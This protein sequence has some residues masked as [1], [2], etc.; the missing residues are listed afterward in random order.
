MNPI[1]SPRDQVIQNALALQ[2][3]PYAVNLE[4][5]IGATG[6]TILYRERFSNVQS[7]EERDRLI[8]QWRGR[9]RVKTGMGWKAG[10][11]VTRTNSI[12]HFCKDFFLPTVVNR[13]SKEANLAFRVLGCVFAAILDIVTLPVRFLALLPLTIYRHTSPN[14]A[15]AILRARMTQANQEQRQLIEEALTLNQ[16]FIGYT[17]T[18]I[19]EPSIQ[20]LDGSLPHR[21]PNQPPTVLINTKTVRET[22]VL[23]DSRLDNEVDRHYRWDV[24]NERVLMQEHEPEATPC[25]LWIEK[26]FY[27][28]RHWNKYNG[29]WDVLGLNNSESYVNRFRNELPFSELAQIVQNGIESGNLCPHG[30]Y[31]LAQS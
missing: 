3:D 16:V 4:I 24:T 9:F 17:I 7:Q 1:L 27:T 30:G 18:E 23:N 31:S 14:P 11:V 2:R 5:R 22:V 10:L 15:I 19:A 25:L 26:P 12:E 13:V 20:A 29:Q 8:K 28:G 6:G 21:N